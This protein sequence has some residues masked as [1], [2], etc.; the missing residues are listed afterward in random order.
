MTS[1]DGTEGNDAL[2]GSD[3]DDVINGLDGNDLLIGKAGTDSINGGAGDDTLLGNRGDDALRGGAGTD[4]LFG[5]EGSDRYLFGLGWGDDVIFNAPAFDSV[6]DVDAIEFDT[7]ILPEDISVSRQARDIILTHV[8][9]DTI[10]LARFDFTSGNRIDEVRFEN[11]TVWTAA[12]LI[13]MS[14]PGTEGDDVIEGTSGD[15]ILNGLGGEDL[16][17]GND[18]D[19][20]VD[21]GDDDDTIFGQDGND[22]LR[23]GSGD[24]TIFGDGGDDQ[25]D[26]GAG[27]DD[28]TGGAGNDVYRFDLGW[29]NDTISL[30]QGVGNPSDRDIIQFGEGIF[31]ADF[32]ASADDRDLVL[33]HT[34]GDTLTLK[35]FFFFTTFQAGE[36]RFADGTVIAPSDMII[37]TVGTED[38]DTLNGVQSGTWLDELLGGLGN[39]ILRGF[40]GD[41]LLFGGGGTDTLQGGSGN[42][43][44]DGGADGDF[45][46]GDAG[47]DEVLGGSGNDLL[48]G[49]D[50]DDLL[51]G[52]EG[53][54]QLRGEEGRDIY[55]FDL[56]WGEDII[57]NFDTAETTSEGLVRAWDAIAFGEG[58][59]QEDFTGYRE[60]DDL[61]L[62]HSSGDLVVVDNQYLS[63]DHEVAFIDFSD[64]TFWGFEILDYVRAQDPGAV[65]VDQDGVGLQLSGAGV[66]QITDRI[67]TYDL[68]YLGVVMGPETSP[69]W[70]A[71]AAG[72]G[73]VS[74]YSVLWQNTAGAYTVWNTDATGAYLSSADISNLVDFEDR[75]QFDF[76]GDNVIGHT[77]TEIDGIGIG[78][79]SSTRGMYQLVDGDQTFDLSYL[80]VV[81]GPE[82]SP[83]WQALAAGVGDVSAY[84]VLWQNTAGAYT[85]WNT[86]ATGAY[87]S[88]A[89]ISNLVDFEDRFQFDFNGD[90]L[91]LG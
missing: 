20:I 18:G 25:I 53:N 49:G 74:A 82:T 24:D 90:G 14:N 71:L 35:D 61:V 11:G 79:Q 54:D 69:G 62:R 31:L 70:Q 23:G 57:H 73:D 37:T 48:F 66:Y 87:L 85:V 56:G 55:F 75:F 19:D 77:V 15:D 33:S 3:S 39:D 27:D 50:D 65:T 44:V 72:V 21:G 40:A 51:I 46:Y 68:S 34:G 63:L 67:A 58:I 10:T 29:G 32:T 28:L 80:G 7:D 13:D 9:G 81:M 64:G 84:S 83:G 45:V 41:D 52:G 60:G 16:V 1:I 91:F 86:D 8:N 89:D 36:A 59:A 5:D 43:L 2:Q 38:D 22:T 17:T 6:G 12:D 47:N 88:S 30:N 76:N 42:D 26:G 4:V 78:L